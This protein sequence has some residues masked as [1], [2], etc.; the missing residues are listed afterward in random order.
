MHYEG[1]QYPAYVPITDYRVYDFEK[2]RPDAIYIHNPYDYANYV[3]SVSPEFY[4]SE[5][6]K[7]TECLVYIPYYSTSGGMSEGQR[8]CPAY[9]Q[10]DLIVMQDGKIPEVF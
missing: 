5:L 1:D 6:K 3:T 2:R 9:Y 10:A 4:S 8:R 7:Y